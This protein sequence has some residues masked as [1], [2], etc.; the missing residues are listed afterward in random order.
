MTI[1]IDPPVTGDELTTSP[2]HPRNWPEPCYRRVALSPDGTQ[3][4]AAQTDPHAA[5]SVE[6]DLLALVVRHGAGRSFTGSLTSHGQVRDNVWCLEI[7]DGTP[8]RV[9]APIT[10]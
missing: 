5:A 2:F 1:G 4:V 6:A 8:I 7:H 9:A 10:V 3:I